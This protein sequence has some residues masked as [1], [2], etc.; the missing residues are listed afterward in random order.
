VRN[1]LQSEEAAFR[2]LVVVAGVV[3]AI[4]AVILAIRALT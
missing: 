1:P 3:V 2:L 4:I